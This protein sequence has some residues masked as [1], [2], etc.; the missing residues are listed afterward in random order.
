[1]AVTWT[2]KD[3]S[4]ANLTQQASTGAPLALNCTNSGDLHLSVEAT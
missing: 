1:M 4:G 2:L 3:G